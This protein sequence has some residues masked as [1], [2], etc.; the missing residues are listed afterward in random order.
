MGKTLKKM[1]DNQILLAN[2]DE[3]VKERHPAQVLILPTQ[4]EKV[5]KYPQIIHDSPRLTFALLWDCQTE[6]NTGE[7]GTR[8][9]ETERSIHWDTL[10]SIHGDES[11]LKIR[12]ESLS[13]NFHTIEPWI[14]SELGIQ[15]SD[16]Q[17]LLQLAKNKFSNRVLN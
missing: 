3:L 9:T 1:L 15:S 17:L 10:I 11:V 4:C 12:V 8:S 2:T 7:L 6:S 14:V 5:S 16:A 13:E